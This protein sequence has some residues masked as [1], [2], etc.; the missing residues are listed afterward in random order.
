V[1]PR[2]AR[3]RTRRFA[4]STRGLRSWTEP[5]RS[6]QTCSRIA[7]VGLPSARLMARA[8]ADT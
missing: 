6:A 2:I 3:C 8:Y 4:I 1:R 7:R 5:R